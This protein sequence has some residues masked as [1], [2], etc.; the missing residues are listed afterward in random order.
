MSEAAAKAPPTSS[1]LINIII[2][3]GYY[4]IGNFI[5]LRCRVSDFRG[6]GLGRLNIVKAPWGPGGRVDHPQQLENEL[7]SFS[8]LGGWVCNSRCMLLAHVGQISSARGVW[9]LVWMCG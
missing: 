9:S 6:L 5:A 8:V 1:R 2:P 7:S 3:Y 4:I